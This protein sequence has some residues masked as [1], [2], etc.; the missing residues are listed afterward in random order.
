LRSPSCRDKF[1]IFLTWEK[2]LGEE[3]LILPIYYVSCD[4]L[5]AADTTDEIAA[6]LR[7]R[8]WADWRSFRFKDLIS[9]ELREQIALLATTI[10]STIKVLETVLAA[11]QSTVRHLAEQPRQTAETPVKLAPPTP[12]IAEVPQ[13]DET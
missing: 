9:S 5:H 12:F 2:E 8:N 10:K 13:S 11:S 3:H 6:V 1:E 4:E 7:T